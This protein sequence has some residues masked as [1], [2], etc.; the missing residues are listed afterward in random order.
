VTVRRLASNF[1]GHIA[2]VI[3]SFVSVP[4]FI[5][6]LGIES[7]GVIGFFI[8]VQALLSMMDLGIGTA[9]TREVSNP[10][11]T[12]HIGAI[13]RWVDRAYIVYAVVLIPVSSILAWVTLQYWLNAPAT[14]FWEGVTCGFLCLAASAGRV[15]IAGYQGILRGARAEVSL[16]VIVAIGALMK[17][18]IAAVVL[19]FTESGLVGFGILHAAATLFECFALRRV[20]W[21]RIRSVSAPDP[22]GSVAQI[23][24]FVVN[25][26]KLGG[27]A[28]AGVIAA[29]ADKFVASKLFSATT[30]AHYLV[31][32]QGA[33]VIFMVTGPVF[34]F[35]L[36]QLSQAADNRDHNLLSE[37]YLL[38]VRIFLVLVVPLTITILWWAE[39]LLFLWTRSQEVASGASGCLRFLVTAAF[40][41]SLQHW[42]YAIQVAHRLNRLPFAV[43]AIGMLVVPAIGVFAGPTWGAKGVAAGVCVWAFCSVT[44]SFVLSHRL[45]RLRNVGKPLLLM[46]GKY[47][48]AMGCGV[49]VATRF[50]G[51]F[52]PI[53]VAGLCYAGLLL[54]SRDPVYLLARSFARK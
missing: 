53:L 24:R 46:A 48:L 25:A 23:E 38:A 50:N 28:V 33:A 51:V 41:S 1:V 27:V 40:F 16:N 3:C 44:V 4:L 32:A 5:K 47:I 20:S 9:L 42:P 21:S 18:P 29:N 39:P 14:Q 30:L 34:Y 31:G 8:S 11:S 22:S 12:A 17:G 6:W 2:V 52:V 54:V 49:I 45:A 36:P 43:N 37:R 19:Y 7:Y 13:L 26:L 15:A 10:G 35:F